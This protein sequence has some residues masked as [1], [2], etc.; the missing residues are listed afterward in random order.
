[1]L[2]VRQIST[3]APFIL[4]GWDLHEDHSHDVNLAARAPPPIKMSQ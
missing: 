3:S 2:G 1:M 4:S